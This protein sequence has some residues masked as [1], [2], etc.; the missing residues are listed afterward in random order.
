MAKFKITFKHIEESFY[1]AII[2]AETEEKAIQIFYNEPFD[3]LLDEEPSGVQ[4]IDI[5]IESTKQVS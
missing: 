4:G 3:H 2:D 5:E 1:T